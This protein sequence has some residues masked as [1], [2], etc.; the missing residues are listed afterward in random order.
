MPPCWRNDEGTRD[1]LL[2]S[3]LPGCCPSSSAPLAFTSEAPA[4]LAILR[5]GASVGLLRIWKATQGVNLR[6]RLTFDLFHDSDL[7]SIVVQ[8]HQHLDFVVARGEYRVSR[9]GC[10]SARPGRSWP[11]GSPARAARLY[12]RCPVTRSNPLRRLFR[13]R[14]SSS[15][16]AMTRS[17]LRS[18]SRAT[19]VASAFPNCPMRVEGWSNSTTVCSSALS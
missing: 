19:A 16:R 15:A 2:P 12:K 13:Q 11:A 14:A 18:R 3:V 6:S 10:A 17:S 4:A 5:G 7:R 1:R 9:R 8:Y